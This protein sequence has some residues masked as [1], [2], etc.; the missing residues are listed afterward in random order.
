[1]TGRCLHVLVLAP[2]VVRA[3]EDVAQV[4]RSADVAEL[5]FDLLGVRDAADAARWIA[6]CPLPVLA[7]LRSVAHGGA[8]EGTPGDAAAFLSAVARVDGVA[9]LDAEADVA[10]LLEAVPAH[11]SVL[12]SVHGDH[13]PPPGPGLRKIARPVRSAAALQAL[14]S[15][16]GNR[17]VSLVPYDALGAARG[18]FVRDVPGT[19]F[20]FGAPTS[21]E[22]NA[23]VVG[24]P[25]LAALRDELRAG[26]VTSACALFGLVGSPPAWSPSP[27]LH[28]AVFR[29]TG[30]D[31][32][33]VPLSGLPLADA[34]ALPCR[35]LAVTTP[36][37]A[38]AYE[39]AHERSA[40]CEATGVANTLVRTT[41]GWRADNTDVEG[42][43]ALC[44]P[45]QPG[46]TAIVYG[47]GATAR[48]AIV[49]LRRR[50]YAPRLVSRGHRGRDVAK[51]FDLLHERHQ[52]Q[53]RST[54]RV[55]VNATPVGATVPLPPFLRDVDL[56]GLCVVDAPYRHA[57]PTDLVARCRASG[58]SVADGRAL[59]IAQA[60]QQVV[61]FSGPA[62]EQV[63]GWLTAA[64]AP[65]PS[66]WLVG[67]RGV[68]KTTVGA[69]LAR[70]WGRPF[71]DLDAEVTR[72]TGRTPG[73]WIRR[74]GWAAFRETERR[75]V[76]QASG[77]RGW[78]WPP[79]R[80]WWNT[81]ATAR[82][83]TMGSLSGWRRPH[84]FVVN[85]WQPIRG[86]VPRTPTSARVTSGTDVG[87][88]F[89]WMRRQ[90]WRRWWHGLCRR[91]VTLGRRCVVG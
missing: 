57:A 42:I 1:M 70:H 58:V 50:G 31:A 3:P 87:R 47:D 67:H 9:W 63:A 85:A 81:R 7:T 38:A 75:V 55:L 20:L 13:P 91:G 45:A 76:A 32:L 62:H 25:P 90:T 28:N 69:A 46:D 68:G 51:A 16:A 39:V 17:D 74:D 52:T 72:S 82:R 6:A 35:G 54:D 65:G 19:T 48:S 89:G 12:T 22:A 66:V 77:R 30:Q 80:A 79:A 44:A 86:T 49:A 36:Y 59:L 78:S 34:M 61:V 33:F 53:R 71:V 56:R 60:R 84:T 40:A 8:F 37:K 21:D 5:R 83:C 41:T 26:E 11:V 29:A 43:F 27:A 18:A 23:V 14:R 64:V 15:Q 2:P 10:P 88:V 73:D 4:A 24:Q